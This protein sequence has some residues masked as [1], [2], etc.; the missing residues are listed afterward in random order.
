MAPG[1]PLC[2]SHCP[3]KVDAGWQPDSWSLAVVIGPKPKGHGCRCCT[4]LVGVA[5]SVSTASPGCSCGCVERWAQWGPVAWWDAGQEGTGKP[6]QGPWECWVPG[7]PAP[8]LSCWR[9][10]KDGFVYR[11]PWSQ[12]EGVLPLGWAAGRQSFVASKDLAV[13]P[14]RPHTPRKERYV[15]SFS[16]PL[17]LPPSQSPRRPS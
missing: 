17:S 14:R 1:C 5:L 7:S 16:L 15:G 8:A 11:W 2:P 12:R 10:H 3:S 9:I 6:R 13:R 4:E